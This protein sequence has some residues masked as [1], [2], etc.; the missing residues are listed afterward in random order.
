M[1]AGGVPTYNQRTVTPNALPNAYEHAGATAEAFGGQVGGAVGRLGGAVEDWATVLRKRDE[2]DGRLWALQQATEMRMAAHERDLGQR[3]NGPAD[4]RGHMAL[5]VSAYDEDAD[6]R[7]QNAPNGHAQKYLQEYALS[8]RDDVGKTAR[9]YEYEAR[10]RYRVTAFDNELE[11]QKA[12]LVDN[13]GSIEFANSII[14]SFGNELPEA[15]REEMVPKAR[16]ALALS[17]VQS[18]V[19]RDPDAAL[20]ALQE[21]DTSSKATMEGLYKALEGQ[22]SGGNAG[23]VSPKGALGLMQLM[24]DTAKEVAE[25][26]G[27]PFDKDRLTSDPEYNRALGRAYLDFQVQKYE[28]NLVMA[29]AAYNAGPG[30]VDAW[31]KSIGDPLKGEISTEEWAAKIPYKE[32]RDYIPGVLRRVAGAPSASSDPVISAAWGDLSAEGKLWAMRQAESAAKQKQADTKILLSQ[33]TADASEAWLNGLVPNAEPTEAQMV[34]AHGAEKGAI[35]WAEYQDT[36]SMGQTI[37]SYRGMPEAEIRQQHEARRPQLGDGYAHKMKL[38]EAEGGAV[39]QLLKR[40]IEDPMGAVIDAHPKLKGALVNAKA[41]DLPEL[42][43]A[44][45]SAQGELGIPEGKRSLMTKSVASTVAKRSKDETLSQEERIA[46][47]TQLIS[48][49][50]TPEHRQAIWRQ[51]EREGVPEMLGVAMFAA[52]MNTPAAFHRVAALALSP[53]AGKP[54]QADAQ[55]GRLREQVHEMFSRDSIGGAL[56]PGLDAEGH[57]VRDNFMNMALRLINNR[58]SQNGGDLSEARRYTEETLWGNSRQVKGAGVNVILQ[59]DSNPDDD[60]LING[61]NFLRRD[62][63]AQLVQQ[64][65]AALPAA[66]TDGGSAERHVVLEN[67]KRA[68]RDMAARSVWV[69][70]GEGMALLDPLTDGYILDVSG[71]PLIVGEDQA[72]KVGAEIWTLPDGV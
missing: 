9:N 11:K 67:G 42:Y 60:T 27:L 40:R 15:K 30:A 58:M 52:E 59:K 18:Q 2:D 5:M 39:E 45:W 1:R 70:Y 48:Q 10:Q 12:W 6:T 71:K 28:G 17:A 36:R 3:E 65:E 61:L 62:A 57:K 19:T 23:A 56:F 25:R 47:I 49:A 44:L 50:K 26:L 24:P 33:V 43:T 38:W 72:R 4:G 14:T 8:F 34:Y 21:A 13:P 37:S 69:K 31:R 54:I 29:L 64:I 46:P 41:E 55:T 22:E 68:A 35:M 7:L 51:L 16:N 53:E 32:T 66:D 20:K 63:E